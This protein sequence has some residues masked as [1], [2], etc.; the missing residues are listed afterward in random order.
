MVCGKHPNLTP[1]GAPFYIASARA[2]QHFCCCRSGAYEHTDISVLDSHGGLGSCLTNRPEFLWEF[3]RSPKDG[4]HFNGCTTK[5]IHNA[6]ASNDDFPNFR[7]IPLLERC[8]LTAENGKVAR[9]RRR[10]AQSSDQRTAPSL[11]R[12]SRGG[13][14]GREEI[15]ATIQ[16][17]SES[18]AAS[19]LIMGKP[20]GP[21][22]FGKPA[23]DFG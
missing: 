17:A 5:A 8:G 13:R 4:C 11:W 1:K 21:V 22:Q 3:S 10:F 6:K 12:C 19:G 14:G 7:I 16:S 18:K 23:L 20:L 2:N 15:V 9:Q